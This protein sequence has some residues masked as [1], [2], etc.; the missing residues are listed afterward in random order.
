[1]VLCI[2][3]T[4]YFM[5]TEYPMVLCTMDTEF[6]EIHSTVGYRFCVYTVLCIHGSVYSIHSTVLFHGTLYPMVLCI[7]WNSVSYGYSVF[8]EIHSIHGT[9]SSMK[10]TVS[11]GTVYFMEYSVSIGTV[12]F[13]ELCIPW[14]CVFP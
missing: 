14:Y 1:M 10:Y 2:H 7:S 3:G 4:V 13:M 8:H 11:H 6:H 5:D 12:Y 9:V